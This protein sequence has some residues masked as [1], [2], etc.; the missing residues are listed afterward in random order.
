LEDSGVVYL[1]QKL[2]PI[3]ISWHIKYNLLRLPKSVF[4]ISKAGR[5]ILQPFSLT[6][7]AKSTIVGRV[8]GV[9]FFVK[10]N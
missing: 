5:E 3:L 2:C 4:K 9:A 7:I 10:N 6:F 1:V 8:A